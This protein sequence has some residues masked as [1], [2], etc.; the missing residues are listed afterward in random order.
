MSYQ[1]L[2]IK[3]S[4]RIIQA[5]FIALDT[6]E[7]MSIN[8]FKPE[9]DIK[10]LPPITL[11]EAALNHV[12]MQIKKQ[13]KGIGLRL[14][15]KTTGCSGKSYQPEIAETIE[16]DEMVFQVAEDVVVLAN[17]TDYLLYLTGLVI[18]FQKQGLNAAF[19]YSNPNEKGA[20]GCGESFTVA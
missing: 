1:P 19:K 5:P 6:T 18:D 4:R 12:R 7:T 3:N 8:I 20:C 15:I 17:K 10:N 14:R 11:T 13:Q 9:Q 2:F 16:A